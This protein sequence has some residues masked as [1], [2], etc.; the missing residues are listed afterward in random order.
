MNTLIITNAPFTPLESRP[1]PASFV[2]TPLQTNTKITPVASRNPIDPVDARLPDNAGNTLEKARKVT[3]ND[4]QQSYKDYVSRNDRLDYYRFELTDARR[5]SL[6]M[7]DLKADVDVE[8]LNSSGKAIANSIEGGTTA[9]K[10]NKQLDPGVYYVKVYPFEIKTSPYTLTLKATLPPVVLPKISITATDATAA[11]VITGET[12]NPGQFT[13]SRTGNTTTALQINYTVS[14]SATKGVDY[15]NVTNTDTNAGTITIPIGATSA[16]I[17]LKITDDTLVED[18]ENIVFT[19]NPNSA[20]QIVTNTATISLA[21][22]DTVVPPTVVDPT[23]GIFTATGDNSTDAL[24]N[25]NFTLWNTSQNGGNITYSFYKAASGP[26]YGTEQVAEVSDAIKTNVRKILSNL[27]TVLNVNFVEV[28]DTKTTYGVVRYMFSNGPGY[29]YAYYPSTDRLGGDVHFNAN[30]ENDP[31]NQFS[32]AEGTY[33]YM[34]IIHETCHAIALKHP[35]NYDAGSGSSPGPYL[36]PG[37]DNITNTLMSYNTVGA[38]AITLMPY[39]IRTLQYLYGARETNPGGTT[40][41]FDSISSYTADGV[42]LGTPGN[43]RQT[44][45][46]S[47]GIDTLDFSNLASTS[48]YRFDLRG[49]GILTAQSAY[50]ASS[51]VDAAGGATFKT[52]T[53]GTTIAFDTMIEDV[54]TTKGNDTIVSNDAANIFSGYTKGIAAGKDIYEETDA[55]DVIDL[56]GFSLPDLQA[57]GSLSGADL[58]IQLDATSSIQ[59]RNYTGTKGSLRVKLGEDFY[60]YS[61]AGWQLAPTSGL[62]TRNSQSAKSSGITSRNTAKPSQNLPV[63]K[64]VRRLNPNR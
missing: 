3:V 17:D 13:I 50:N 11:E 33:G 47:D 52:S 12:Q 22:N 55:G 21:D 19:L 18:A 36:N 31:L 53:Y 4:Q 49:G 28:A 51:Y 57:S 45:W 61:A 42:R 58:S 34:G 5:F 20:Y 29:A 46:D 9:E 7:T 48:D 41:K 30:Y 39:D 10:I 35:G 24:L 26:Y 37:D 54:V 43:N 6:T 16:T 44:L 25:P 64:A 14:G 1:N 27:S 56:K 32:G 8:L 38:N 40:Y 62:P 59:V 60:R 23:V 2:E 15:N 63:L